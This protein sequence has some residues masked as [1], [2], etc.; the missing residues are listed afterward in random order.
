M[1]LKGKSDTPLQ[2][3]VFHTLAGFAVFFSLISVPAE[4]Q[5]IDFAGISLA[6]ELLW[7]P[8]AFFC[9]QL[10]YEIY[11]LAYLRHTLYLV[12][13]CRTVYILFLKFAIWLPASSF[14]SMQE[15]YSQVLGRDWNYLIKSSF[16][17]WAFI[18]LPNVLCD[19]LNKIIRQYS[20]T[21]ALLIFCL[22]N[23]IWINTRQQTALT[24]LIIPLLLFLF[25][26][27]FFSRLSN[28]ISKIE[29]FQH[30]RNNQGSIFTFYVPNLA[31]NR[32]FKYHHLLFCSSIV[33]FIASK[34]MAAKFISIGFFTINV[35]GIVFSL[36]Y[37]AADMM[38][39]VY[40]IERTKQMVLF[41]IFCNLLLVF[42][43]W[44]TNH[45]AIGEND[46]FKMVLHNQARMFIASATA[47]F[48]GMTINSTVISIIKSKQR[49]RG[50]VL[51]KE[52][53][54]TVWTRIATSSA[55]GI[56]IDVSLFSLVAFYGIVPNEKLASVIVFEDA[57][58]IFYEFLLA[59]ISIL[60]IYFLKVKE[61]VDIYDEL[62]NLNP[63]RIDTN[64]KLNA[65]KFHENYIN[66]KNKP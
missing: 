56:I 18:L 42:D 19:R 25:L 60:L 59:P 44:L 57:Y 53:I 49:R 12:I 26:N 61:K 55:F 29:Q 38:T 30:H 43:V 62:S 35:G 17:L 13:M 20:T 45:L 9:F 21:I 48:L 1:L 33:F 52:F 63:F 50:I 11:G 5:L 16:L 23:L 32:K 15:V 6:S 8:M 54:T 31:G 41:V 64:Y 37:L 14:W 28:A 7:W 3:K 2:F 66:P 34:T 65:N 22:L 51:K 47:Y 27:I 58:K 40:G 36:A 4:A 39:D 24:Q 10:I 46:P